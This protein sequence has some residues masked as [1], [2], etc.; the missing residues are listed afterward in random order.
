MDKK[1]VFYR[2]FQIVFGVIFV[3]AI[4]RYGE[5][6]IAVVTEKPQKTYD[7]HLE[8][9]GK[10]SFES[11]YKIEV[12]EFTGK[13]APEVQLSIESLQQA[14]SVNS[15]EVKMIVARTTFT[16]KVQVIVENAA[17]GSIEAMAREIGDKMPI[18]RFDE[19]EAK[20]YQGIIGIYN[21]TID[22]KKFSIRSAY[23]AQGQTIYIVAIIYQD[24]DFAEADAFRIL[25]S[26]NFVS[27]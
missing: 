17:Q 11:P 21:A 16:P 20:P 6:L 26:I 18:P 15:G 27:L 23:I 3:F 4:I 9:F 12:E 22:S 1:K 5:Q 19:I 14:K 25:D 7:W 10:M 13:L 24:K 8:T 2:I